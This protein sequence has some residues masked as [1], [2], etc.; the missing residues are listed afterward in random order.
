MDCFYHYSSLDRFYGVWDGSS[1]GR[2][3]LLPLRRV[4]TLG[5][6]RRF[7]LPDKAEEGAIFGLLE[8][9]PENWM[10]Q[11]YYEGEGFLETIIEDILLRGPEMLLLRCEVSPED[12]IHVAEHAFHMHPKYKGR[13]KIK[14]PVT[15]QV[16]RAYWDSMVP[17]ADYD[18]GY[19]L[20]EVICF[21]PI[22]LERIKI[23]RRYETGLDLLDELREKVGKPPLARP[24]KPD[25][26]LQA[27]ILDEIF[28]LQP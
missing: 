4:L 8:P 17:L 22:P 23:M 2:T 19:T 15:K 24:K 25:P 3:G 6:A 14:S 7:G 9:Q 1:Y 26:A 5:S 28:G 13:G 20:P 12:D 10:R 11:E 16:K 18:G 27:K 21:S